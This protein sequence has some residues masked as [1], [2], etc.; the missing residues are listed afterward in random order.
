MTS[1][2]YEATLTAFLDSMDEA[3][4]DRALALFA[5]DATYVRPVLNQPGAPLGVGITEYHGK[6]EIREF[7][8][9]RGARAMRQRIVISATN[10]RHL[11]AEGTIDFADGS[12]SLSPLFHLVFD[13]EGRIERFMAVR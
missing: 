12:P 10:E 2:D 1:D 4:F 3:D 13:D 7:M 6:Q 9:A 11:F 5:D 8:R